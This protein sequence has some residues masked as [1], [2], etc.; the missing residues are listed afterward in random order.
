MEKEDPGGQ[1][2]RSGV[3]KR[4]DGRKSG[5]PGGRGSNQVGPSKSSDSILSVVG[6]H[7]YMSGLAQCLA[8]YSTSSMSGWLSHDYGQ[9]SR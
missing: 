7:W 5:L 8:Y 6:S 4:D 9:I 2:S 1:G 3:R